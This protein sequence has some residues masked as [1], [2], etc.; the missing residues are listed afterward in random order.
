MGDERT[1]EHLLQR[2]RASKRFDTGI[3]GTDILCSVLAKLDE[4][5][6]LYT[7]LSQE[8]FPSFGFMRKQGATTILEDWDGHNSRNHPMFGGCVRHLIEVFA[9]VQKRGD[10]FVLTP[11]LPNGLTF[12]R[13]EEYSDRGN[14]KA[15]IERTA[16]GCEVEIEC[17][18]ACTLFLNGKEYA[19]CG[20]LKTEA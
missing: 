2:Y 19:V 16:T 13:V 5:E 6:L 15:L 3:F 18:R 7:L 14:L 20:A 11:R 17:D 4:T 9:G 1:K 12:V 10:G 8:E